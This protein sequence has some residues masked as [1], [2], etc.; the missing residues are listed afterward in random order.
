MYL[1]DVG[2]ETQEETPGLLNEITKKLFVKLLS[3]EVDHKWPI[4]RK[5]HLIYYFNKFKDKNIIAKSNE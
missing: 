4:N 3:S 2:A 5:T 1:T